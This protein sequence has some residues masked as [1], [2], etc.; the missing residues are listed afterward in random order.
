M[1]A[2]LTLH[3]PV[4]A[5]RLLF[6]RSFFDDEPEVLVRLS[7]QR[8]AFARAAEALAPTSGATEAPTSLDA[9]VDA[10][11]TYADAWDAFARR[12]IYE[13]GFAARSA[14]PLEFAWSVRLVAP[15]S[16]P[17]AASGGGVTPPPTFVEATPLL[18]T[19][20]TRLALAAALQRRGAVSTLNTDD[21]R[22][23]RALLERLR[24]DVLD[25]LYVPRLAPPPPRFASNADAPSIDALFG[26]LVRASSA[27]AASGSRVPPV[28]STTLVRALE[29][30]LAGQQGVKTAVALVRAVDA[31][32]ARIAA[33][34]FGA[35]AAFA[36]ASRLT[37]RHR[38]FAA[39]TRVA[40]ALAHRYTAQAIVDARERGGVV[41]SGLDVAGGDDPA[42]VVGVA[43]AFARHAR[44]AEPTNVAIAKYAAEL[45]ERNRLE[46][47]MQTVPPWATITL[48]TTA[49]VVEPDDAVPAATTT[50]TTWLALERRA[51]PSTSAGEERFVATWSAPYGNG[52]YVA[53]SS[54]HQWHAHVTRIDL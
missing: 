53:A 34:L 29:R 8:M 43:V 10:I 45:E 17:D 12:T 25:A 37:P 15:P 28:F 47:R 22:E 35:R 19:A 6:E 24:T 54:V 42:A 31:S 52:D 30:A 36:E 13:R 33:T 4:P 1:S 21:L 39:A 48:E 44:E 40:E 18:E 7:E 16:S 14:L 9:L 11:R 46:F 5:S 49:G 38:A 27:A 32:A 3:P 51:P 23:A 26:A 50:T 41:V 20:C 2:L